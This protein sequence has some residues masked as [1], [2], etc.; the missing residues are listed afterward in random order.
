MISQERVEELCQRLEKLFIPN[1]P[2]HTEHGARYYVRRSILQYLREAQPDGGGYERV[3]YLV[4]GLLRDCQIQAT[5][6]RQ[7]PDLRAEYAAQA[8]AWIEFDP[9]VQALW[10]PYK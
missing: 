4:R 7:S 1:G 8:K 9:M 2:L 3:T 10:Y 5:N 6:D